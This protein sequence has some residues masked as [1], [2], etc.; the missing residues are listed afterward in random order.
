MEEAQLQQ[1]VEEISLKHFHRPFIHNA[2]FNHRLRTTGG[3]YLLHTHHIEINPK[4]LEYYGYEE[5]VGIIKHELCHYHLH[6]EGKGYRHRDEDFKQLLSKVGGQR[7]CKPLPQENKSIVWRVYVCNVCETIYKRKRRINVE[8]Y[9]CGKC[10]GKL[11]EI[12]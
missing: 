6:I 12:K 5:L 10:H 8:R 4:H 3:R 7:F 9:V 11:K 2:R 1:L